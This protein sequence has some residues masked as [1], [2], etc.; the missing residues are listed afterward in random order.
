MECCAKSKQ[1]MKFN[2]KNVDV[3]PCEKGYYVLLEKSKIQNCISIQEINIEKEYYYI[4]NSQQNEQSK[5]LKKAFIFLQ[6]LINLSQ[7]LLIDK[8]IQIT[9][10]NPC[11]IYVDQQ[12]VQ[13]SQVFSHIIDYQL[14]LQDF[15]FA[16]QNKV[17]QIFEVL[18]E[19]FNAADQYPK[20]IKK[21]VSYNLISE[22]FNAISQN[23]RENA[24]SLFLLIQKCL[25][26]LELVLYSSQHFNL[27]IFDES[28]S[29]LELI[30]DSENIEQFK[31]LNKILK[32]NSTYSKK[33]EMEICEDSLINDI[34]TIGKQ[35]KFE[36]ITMNIISNWDID[37]LNLDI[38]KSVYWLNIS[39][40]SNFLQI[41]QFNSFQNI[42]Q[43]TFFDAQQIKYVRNISQF[44]K[45][46]YLLSLCAYIR[47]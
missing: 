26:A 8:N 45:L 39:Q 42:Q 38:F 47:Y 30:L 5:S 40:Q 3:I 17:N 33:T 6:N 13:S 27:Q 12:D 1:F 34:I 24:S 20:S 23:S 15:E 44:F 10:I 18:K 37:F 16:Y 46:K 41:K 11:N 31:K 9:K 35:L 36:V 28:K 21:I 32:N 7:D 25:K 29:S 4:F 19:K 22:Y 43:I 14:F 2:I